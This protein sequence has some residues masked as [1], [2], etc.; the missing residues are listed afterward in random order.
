VYYVKD[1]AVDYDPYY[2]LA[3]LNSRVL[4][5]YYRFLYWPVHL[6]GGYLRVNSPYLARLPLP[7][8]T[9]PA[10]A[11]LAAAAREL[12]AHPERIPEMQPAL[13]A[14]VCDLYEIT[15]DELAEAEAA[16]ATLTT[17]RQAR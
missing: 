13:D 7:L 12:T 17:K 4:A 14:A 9:A 6:G 3:L 8:P 15:M 16:L 5:W 1:G 11:T 10:G 2:L